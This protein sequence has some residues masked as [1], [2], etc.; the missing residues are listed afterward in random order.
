[1]TGNTGC[2]CEVREKIYFNCKM[3]LSKV[4][5][6]N[7]LTGGRGSFIGNSSHTLNSQDS[8]K[9]KEI[10]NQLTF[11]PLNMRGLCYVV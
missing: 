1:M 4:S 2:M 8:R 6:R 10:S 5:D 3:L 7:L 11:L 9:R